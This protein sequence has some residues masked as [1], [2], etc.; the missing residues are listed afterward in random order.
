MKINK[1]NY[2][3]ITSEII[4]NYEDENTAELVFTSLEKD[5]ENFLKSELNG[6]KIKYNINNKNLGSFLAT[7]D[8]LI[9]C[10]IIVE[11]IIKIK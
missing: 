5:N 11:K 7:A 1:N 8:D 4:F 9:A 6:N 10:E 2:M 3:K